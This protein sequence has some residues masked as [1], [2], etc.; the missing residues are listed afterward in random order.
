MMV[1]NEHKERTAASGVEAR[2]H[3][4]RAPHALGRHIGTGRA[5]EP[6]QIVEVIVD[7]LER[8]RRGVAQH[9]VEAPLRFARI[10]RNAEVERFLERIGRLRQHGEAAG[11][12]EPADHH[13][14][15]GRPQRPGAVHHARELIRL[16]AD[17]A[18]HAETAIV[19][20]LAGDAV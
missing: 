11:D 7:R 16:D 4:E 10:E 19:L 8:A 1:Q 12:M 6:R 3:A 18:D 9:F 5:F 2:D 20:D 17:K 15:A 13:R 14:H